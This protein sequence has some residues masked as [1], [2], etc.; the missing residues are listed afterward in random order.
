MDSAI[1]KT[2]KETYRK[3]YGKDAEIKAI[4]AGLECGILSEP[5]PNWDMIS[6]GPTIRHP[7]SP[8]EKVKVDTVAKFWDFLV[9]VLKDVPAK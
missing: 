6:I 5:Y 4:H 7:H 1:L 2:M 9:A 3:L 8:D